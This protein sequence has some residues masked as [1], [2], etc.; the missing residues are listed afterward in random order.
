MILQLAAASLKHRK[1]SVLLTLFTIVISVSLLLSVEYVRGQVRDSF[2]RTVSGVDIIV[3]APTGQLNLLLYS[4][5]RMGNPTQGVDWQDVA[6]L[7]DHPQVDWLVPI[8][9]GDAHKGY[10]VVG[11]SNAYFEHFKY[12]D[13]QSLSFSTG[14]GFTSD[15]HAVI[16]AEVAEQLNYQVGDKIVI[17]HGLGE[18]SFQ[19][20]ESHPFT[21]SGILN[22]TGTP[23]D[24]GVYVTLQGMESVHGSSPTQN[25][26]RRSPFKKP[27][28][29]S[30]AADDDHAHHDEHDHSAEDTHGESLSQAPPSS[31]SALFL[32]LSSRVAALQVQHQINN[33]GNAALLAI[34][35]GVALKQLWGLM[36]NV[37]KLLLGISVLILISSL[38]GLITLLLATMRERRQ[39]IA[40]LRAIGAGPGTILWLIQAEALLI[41]AVGCAVSFAAVSLG[42]VVFADWLNASYGLVVTGSLFTLQSAIVVGCV[43]AAT[44]VC[45]FIPAIAAYRSALHAGLSTR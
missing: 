28:A 5:F 15:R 10:R 40:V 20:H 43:L 4:V 44:W 27:D 6:W 22:P 16:G 32:G 42:L 7:E 14:N 25:T 3:G 9:L 34:L 35:P 1:T 13:K 2:T 31:I 24:K 23:A 8:A 39:E 37:E 26:L 41:T 33:Y 21:I 36:S 19:H 29:G 11:T 38:I 17:S 18:V 45:S 12:G 30:K